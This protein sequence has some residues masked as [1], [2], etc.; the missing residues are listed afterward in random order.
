MDVFLRGLVAEPNRLRSDF[1]DLQGY[2]LRVT[3]G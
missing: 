2:F 3:F 1:F